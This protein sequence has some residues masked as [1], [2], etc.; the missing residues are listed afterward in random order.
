MWQ[1]AIP[2]KLPER[3]RHGRRSERQCLKFCHHEAENRPRLIRDAAIAESEGGNMG[4]AGTTEGMALLASAERS[5]VAFA[6]TFGVQ[7][8]AKLRQIPA[9]KITAADFPGLPEIPNSDMALPIVD[10]YV[11]P[12]DPYALYAAGKQADVPLLLGYN[13]NES[14]HMF[15]PASTPTF[16]AN[17]RQHYGAMADRI[18]SLYPVSS[19]V[20]AAHSQE[21]LWVEYSFGWHIWT[22]ARLHAQTSHS[23]VYLYHFVSDN[24][25][26]GAE[27]PYVFL[28]GLSR[29]SPKQEREM[30][31]TVSGYWTNFAKAANPNGNA[32][33]NWPPFDEHHQ[34]AMFLGKSPTPGE[35]PDHAQHT[36]MDA[37]M[38]HVRSESA[39]TVSAH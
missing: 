24:A 37:Y 13:A 19:E 26:H 5:G 9:D 35:A 33:P 25:V 18:F 2:G 29:S 8:I 21:R 1:S 17:V 31:E 22:W 10:G 6:K 14:A 15:S 38:S 27:L 11:I 7:S 20:E 16:I 23:K 28:Y 3:G 4:P 30:A 34:T 36:L 12:D 39:Q 32:L